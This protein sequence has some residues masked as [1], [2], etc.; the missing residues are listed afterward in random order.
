MRSPHKGAGAETPVAGEMAGRRIFS[1]GL[2]AFFIVS[3]WGRIGLENHNDAS[4]ALGAT[5]FHCLQVAV[6][7]S[8]QG[9][10]RL[11][12]CVP[13]EAGFRV[14][15]EGLRS[16]VDVRLPAGQLWIAVRA[17]RSAQTCYGRELKL[18]VSHIWEAAINL[19]RGVSAFFGR[20]GE[21]ISMLTADK[22][23]SRPKLTPV[24]AGPGKPAS[25]P[26]GRRVYAVGDVHGRA[27]LLTR[28]I[29]ELNRDIARGGFEGRPILVFLGDYID[30]GFQSR[31]VL[32]I[33]LSPALSSFETYFLK[34]NHESAMLQFLDDPA[35]GPRWGEFGGVETLVSYGVKPPRVRTS[36]EEWARCSEDLNKVLPP[37]HRQFLAS[38]D[39]SVQIGDYVFVHAGMKPGVPLEQ[40]SEYDLLWI[41]E[42]FLEDRR[43]FGPVIVHGHTP[44][45]A[46][47]RD[48]RRIGIDTG[49]Y[50]SGKLTAARFEHDRVDFMMTGARADMVEAG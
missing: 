6:R 50:L 16:P 43:L 18:G 14:A 25:I 46:P 39:L 36:K 48:A 34:G 8:W 5:R 29:A 12:G 15:S 11:P 41:R 10:I 19:G 26:P 33:L 38:L 49:A 20:M 45:A 32:S 1:P 4:F 40:Q 27:D 7:A 42:E 31:E 9:W 2:K 37:E 28:L 21:S 23:R 17:P 30:R 44:S 13:G 3:V 24:P 35:I 22:P 47:Y